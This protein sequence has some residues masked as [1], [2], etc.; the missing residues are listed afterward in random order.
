MIPVKNNFGFKVACQVCKLPNSEDSQIHAIINCE[1]IKTM[2][3]LYNNET[4]KY[5]D[6]FGKCSKKISSFLKVADVALR[7]RL[8]LLEAK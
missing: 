1:R 8:Q 2:F 6:I 5:E 4:V 3:P 7:G